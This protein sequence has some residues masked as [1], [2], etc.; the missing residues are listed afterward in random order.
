LPWS[1]VP[2]AAPN[3]DLDA[4]LLAAIEAH[5]HEGGWGKTAQGAAVACLYLYMVIAGSERD[6]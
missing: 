5:V 4:P 3:K 6:A 2:R 1:L